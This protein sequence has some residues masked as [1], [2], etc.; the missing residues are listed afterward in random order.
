MN[1]LDLKF[2]G[3]LN[4]D[5]GCL[6]TLSAETDYNIC[7]QKET[8]SSLFGDEGLF[9]PTLKGSGIDCIQSMP[10]SMASK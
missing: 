8:K 4:V 5:T 7:L 10:L 9:L 3:V 2:R 6:V 1:A